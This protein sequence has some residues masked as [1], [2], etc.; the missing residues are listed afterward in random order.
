MNIPPAPKTFKYHDFA[1]TVILATDSY[2]F[3]CYFDHGQNEPF[4]VLIVGFQGSTLLVQ[5]EQP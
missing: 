2:S 1:Q 3:I 5:F 4:E